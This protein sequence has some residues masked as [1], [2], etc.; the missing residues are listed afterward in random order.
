MHVVNL[1][2]GYDTNGAAMCPG[3]EWLRVNILLCNV[4]VGVCWPMFGNSTW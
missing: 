1:G 3:E 4:L 2:L